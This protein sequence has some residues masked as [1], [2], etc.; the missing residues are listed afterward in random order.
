MVHKHHATRLHYDLRLELKGVLVSWACPRGFSYDPARKHLA[1]PTEDHPLEYG[2]F[3]GRIPE[4]EYGAGDSIIWDRGTWDTVPP[5]EAAAQLQQ[6]HLHLQLQG[7]K[8][9][10]GW[11]LIR[12]R[13]P[14]GRDQWLIYKAKDGLERS[15]YD[16]MT[17]R[18]ESVASGR[19]LTRGPTRRRALGGRQLKALGSADLA[20][21][22]YTPSPHRDDAVGALLLANRKGGHWVFAGKVGTGFDQ[23]TRQRLLDLLRPD[24]VE[25][26]QIEAAPRLRKAHWVKPKHLAQVRFVEWTRDGKL[27][28]PSFLGLREDKAA[29][30]TQLEPAVAKSRR[31][32]RPAAAAPT[33]GF[34]GAEPTVGFGGGRPNRGEPPSGPPPPEVPI[35]HPERILFPKS[36]IT[37]A[38]VR[39]YFDLVAPQLVEAMR[40]RPLSI[41]QWPRGIDHPGFFRHAA[42]TAPA[43]ITRITLEHE[44]H[45][46]EHLVID[47]P[48]TVAWLAN[49]AALTFHLTASRVF[50]LE[51][52]DWVAFD[53]DPAD[54][55]FKK[56][57]PLARAL[58]GLLEQLNLASHPKTSGLRGLH[59]FVPIAPGHSFEQAHTFAASICAALARRFPAQA[60]ALRA[61]AHRNGRLYLDP[62]LN[63]RLKTMVAPYSIR[64]VEGAPV[65]TPLLW[66]EVDLKLDPSQ[67]TI[68]TLEKRLAKV[69]DLFAPVLRGRQR[70]PA[71]SD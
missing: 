66:D 65:S 3:E 4:G 53:F 22:G 7:E 19:R 33:R 27:R 37:R 45:P 47:K 68:K 42:G 11:H 36:K 71:F 70:L 17:A 38:E 48:Q 31:T 51:H 43:W 29:E 8:L 15:D 40:G 41:Q 14:G 34:F 26:A 49:Q 67:F 35:T 44:A 28:H 1:V 58:A 12:T 62:D 50:S 56:V 63:A 21:A 59:V 32:K 54:D 60:T 55:D 25:G 24:E 9:Q 30:E 10:G 6:G 20:I 69:G 52:P 13:P 2:D 64:A 16:L 46:A 61:K 39:A 5:G 23:Q 57:V 18:P